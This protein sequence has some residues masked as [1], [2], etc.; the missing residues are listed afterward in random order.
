MDDYTKGVLVTENT[1]YIGISERLH[2]PDTIRLLHAAIGLATESGEML[3]ALKKY[4]YYGKKL[5]IANLREE[6]GDIFWYSALLAHIAGFTFE[7]TMER[8]LAKLKARY[9]HRFQEQDA[10]IR[11]LEKE[12]IILEKATLDCHTPEHPCPDPQPER[13]KAIVQEILTQFDIHPGRKSG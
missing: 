12:R 2:H 5:D 1:D 8:N 11:D 7:D 9:P 3:D 10:I 6:L 4:I 13:A